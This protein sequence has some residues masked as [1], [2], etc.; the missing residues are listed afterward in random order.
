VA[1]VNPEDMPR[2]PATGKGHWTSAVL[3]NVQRDGWTPLYTAPHPVAQ[4]LTHE[5]ISDMLQDHAR[6]SKE[7]HDFAHAVI[8]EFCRVNGIGE[9]P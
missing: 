2:L 9:Q 8:A 7:M 6:D 3:L 4:P 5:Q 1:W